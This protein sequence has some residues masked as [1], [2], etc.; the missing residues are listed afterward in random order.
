MIWF[1]RV[2]T[3]LANENR[4][5]YRIDRTLILWFKMVQNH[6]FLLS[7]SSIFF[8]LFRLGFFLNLFFFYITQM[9]LGLVQLEIFWT[10]RDGSFE[11]REIAFQNLFESLNHGKFLNGHPYP[12]SLVPLFF[13]SKSVAI[14]Q[15]S[16]SFSINSRKN[17][18]FF[19]F[20][21]SKMA[22]NCLWT[23]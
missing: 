3:Q 16:G 20:S 14:L 23:L 17:W 5:T 15:C 11:M 12:D 22:S 6:L 21:W 4:I 2:K 8:G 13:V 19:T 10:E 9:G 1:E 7:I 18:S